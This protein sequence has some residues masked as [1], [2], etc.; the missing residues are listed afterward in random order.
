MHAADCEN[1]TSIS[2]GNMHW[3]VSVNLTD[4]L[5]LSAH[6]AVMIVLESVGGVSESNKFDISK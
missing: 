5:K 2:Q 6:Y 4:Y 1:W 3:S